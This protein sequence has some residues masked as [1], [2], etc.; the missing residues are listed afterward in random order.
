MAGSLTSVTFL[1]QR[2]K[3][4]GAQKS[5]RNNVKF[6]IFFT[7]SITS[8]LNRPCNRDR[9]YEQQNLLAGLCAFDLRSYFT[10]IQKP[11]RMPSNRI[12][13]GRAQRW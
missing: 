11:M 3:D 1:G 2:E 7:G 12:A 13:L 4:R 8:Y 5:R 10:I 9:T 6:S